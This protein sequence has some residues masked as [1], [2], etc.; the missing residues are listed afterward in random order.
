MVDH[1]KISQ[2]IRLLG[3][4]VKIMALICESTLGECKS[5]KGK[6]FKKESNV[7]MLLMFTGKQSSIPTS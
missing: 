3:S 6:T 4:Y 5:Y 1:G 7:E 2:L